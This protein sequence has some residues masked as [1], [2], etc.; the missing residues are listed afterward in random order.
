MHSKVIKDSS[1]EDKEGSGLHDLPI[2]QRKMGS[3]LKVIQPGPNIGCFASVFIR[4]VMFIVK[5]KT[6]RT[7]GARVWKR[8]IL[9]LNQ[10]REIEQK[11]TAE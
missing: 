5:P 8:W 7:V 10:Y 2:T 6:E 9:Y 4:I 1:A 11:T 3:T